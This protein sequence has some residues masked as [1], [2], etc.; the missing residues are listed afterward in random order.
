MRTCVTPDGNFI[1]GIHKP[2]FKVHNM[3]EE[4]HLQSLGLDDNGN[5]INNTA[6]FPAGEVEELHGEWIYEILNPFPFRGATYIGKSWADF[7]AEDPRAIKLPKPV[8]TSMT[9]YLSW[10]LNSK[11]KSGDCL[12]ESFAGLP[13][14]VLLALASTSTDPDDLIRLAELSCEFVYDQEGKVPTGLRYEVDTKGRHSPKII[15]PDLFEA[16]VNNAALPDIYKEIMVLRPGAQGD[17]EIV[18]EWPTGSDSHVF[19]YMRRNSYIPWGHYASNMANDLVRYSV[20]DI[21]DN[22]FEGLRHLYYQRTYIRLAEQLGIKIKIRNKC[23]KPAEL[24]ELRLTIIKELAERGTS[25]LKFDSTIWGWNYGFD[26]AASGYRLHASHQ[27]IHQQFSMV[28]KEVVRA[29]PKPGM[30]P[31]YNCGDLVADFVR[32]YQGEHQSGFFEDYIRSIRN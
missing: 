31:S 13:E 20:S 8:P 23:F 25:S 4:V 17:S 19:E 6:N 9:R 26:F 2:S 28:P 24:E 15:H 14:T 3:R 18:G 1:Y 32:S 5:P 10:I 30:I 21:S 12:N 11:G 22:D 7:K 27:Q 29:G 16:L